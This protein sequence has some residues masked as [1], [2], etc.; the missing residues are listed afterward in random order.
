M[1]YAVVRQTPHSVAR[2]SIQGLGAGPKCSDMRLTGNS[3]VDDQ[4]EA[5]CNNVKLK[6]RTASQITH[7]MGE[8]ATQASYTVAGAGACAAVGLVPL[9]STCGKIGGFFGK[10]A[11]N[12][13]WGYDTDQ[14]VVFG[15]G[16]AL[17]GAVTGGLCGL[18]A[19]E[20]TRWL[21][22]TFGPITDAVFN[23]S[24]KKDRELAA[25]RARNALDQATV[26]FRKQAD[27]AARLAD[28]TL[29]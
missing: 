19:A 13:V 27:D 7:D 12:R 21:S 28:L 17:C 26:E 6:G 18:A 20:V 4:A 11:F 16:T 8:C 22:D 25:R 1:S 10:W 5:C 2:W 14:K 3:T 24:A 23:P 9:A 29:R 15:V